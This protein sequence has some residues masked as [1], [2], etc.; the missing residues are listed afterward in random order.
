MIADALDGEAV[1]RAVLAARP[2]AVIHQLTAIPQ[3]INPRT[4]RRDFELNDRLRTEGTRILV[5][6]AQQAGASKIIAQSIAFVYEPGPPGTL[7]D[8]QDP[9]VHEPPAS[10]KRSAEAVASLERTVLDANGVVLRYGYF[11]GPGS[12]ISRTGS[13]GVDVQRRRLPI[14]G[15]GTGGG[16]TSTLLTGSLI[17]AGAAA[18][19]R[20]GAGFSLAA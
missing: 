20:W 11:Y 4:Q 7:H 2:E 17:T 16:T 18:T 13:F 8:E 1:Q 3:R 9:L 5:A 12:A 14:V 10:F 6:A 15:S 19:S